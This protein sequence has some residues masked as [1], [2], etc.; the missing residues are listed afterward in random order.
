MKL[1][2]T[3]Q[4]ALAAEIDGHSEELN[5]DMPPST[6]TLVVRLDRGRVRTVIYR[7]ESVRHS[8]PSSVDRR[9]GRAHTAP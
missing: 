1:H 9:N 7:A 6:L 2:E 8:P 4:R 5:S 3:I